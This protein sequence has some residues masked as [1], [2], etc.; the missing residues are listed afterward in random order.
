MLE[1]NKS[2]LLCDGHTVRMISGVNFDGIITCLN[3]EE[4]ERHFAFRV[5]D[6]NILNPSNCLICQKEL[7]SINKL[8]K[9]QQPL[10]PPEDYREG[11][12]AG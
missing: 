3:T 10:R 4:E 8:G 5:M 11:I 9:F 2:K 12:C 7:R 1:S 6:D